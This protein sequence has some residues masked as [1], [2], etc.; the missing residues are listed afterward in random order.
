MSFEVKNYLC[1]LVWITLV[2]L[3]PISSVVAE[4]TP[5][6]SPKKPSEGPFVK[7]AEGYMVPYT[8]RVPGTDELVEMVPVPGGEFLLG[9]PDDEADRRDDEGPQIKLTVDPMWVAKKEVR[10]GLYQEYMDL[11]EIFK[12]FEAKGMRKVADPNQADAIT[13][14]TELYEPSFTYEYGQEKEQ[15][16]VTM[17]QYAAKQFTKWISLLT[18]AQYRLPTEAEWEYAARAGTGTAFSWGD[19]AEGIEE[20]AWYFDNADEGQLPSGEKKPNAFGLYDMHGNVAEWT[21]NA[22]TEDG[23]K[24]FVGKQGMNAT[25]FVIWPE[26][27]SPCVLRGGSWEMDAEELRSAARLASDYEEWRDRKSVV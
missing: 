15:A 4:D 9:S 14:P 12:K 18:G 11:Y 6:I 22:Y 1:R 16:A 2:C 27:P 8:L 20:H 10:W 19:D 23:Y 7:V 5:G 3:F 13:A 17:T 25:D 21:V 26:L 24:S